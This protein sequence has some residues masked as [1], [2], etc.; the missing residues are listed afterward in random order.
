M[1][2]RILL[3]APFFVA[4]AIAAAPTAAQQ[5]AVLPKSLDGPAFWKLIDDLS[6][7][8]GVFPSDNLVS[9]ELWFPSVLDDL[10]RRV[11]AGQVYVGVGPEQNF[12]YIA[13]T[14]P[15][16]AFIL[17]IRRG[18]L[19]MQL[20]YKALFELSDSR[21]AFVSRLFGRN[22]LPR[23]G[24]DATA[25]QLFDAIAALDPDRDAAADFAA[26]ERQLT[27]VDRLPVPRADLGA[28]QAL[29]STFR[30]RGPEISYSRELFSGMP[31][32]STLMRRTDGSRERSYLASEAAFHVV[33]DL[34]TRNLV[35]P[36][37]GN[38]AGPK[39]LRAIGDYARAH[40]ATVDVMYVSNVEY[41]L[42]IDSSWHAFCSNVRSLPLAEA[43]TFVRS[44]NL[45]APA[46]P[47]AG[48]YPSLGSI[49]DQT[50]PCA[51][52]L[53]ARDNR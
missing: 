22:V 6:E 18:N 16:L 8:T 30:E 47:V 29:L 52:A 38:L 40:A 25:G 9:N 44:S 51:T 1:Q 26:V 42:R 34:E 33:K 45:P 4:L 20:M 27:V 21:A 50:A 15:R 35:I 19:Q 37:V 7:P 46:A 49:Q 48:L 39:A 53:G 28:I 32:Y 11:P 31:S 36:I 41:Y 17:D 23:P 3:F 2:R 24:A 5:L 12:S 14:H 10:V 13:A 43:S